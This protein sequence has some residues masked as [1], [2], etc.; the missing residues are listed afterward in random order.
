MRLRFI[1]TDQSSKSSPDFIV[2]ADLVEQF[3]DEYLG[4]ETSQALF[5]SDVEEAG[6]VQDQEHWMRI[7]FLEDPEDPQ[8]VVSEI[9][10][11][12]KTKIEPYKNW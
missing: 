8:A 5:N 11:G 12:L 10:D 6:S 9:A 4:G 3:F 2:V 7:K 1:F